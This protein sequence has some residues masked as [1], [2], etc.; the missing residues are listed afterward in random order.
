MRAVTAG[1][2]LLC[3]GAEAAT[4]ASVRSDVWVKS[5]PE[6]NTPDPKD[7]RRVHVSIEGCGALANITKDQMIQ[8]V[9]VNGAEGIDLQDIAQFD[10]FRAHAN[11]ELRSLWISFHT[12]DVSWLG[13]RVDVQVR[14]AKG[15]PVI[16]EGTAPLASS[17]SGLT[18]SYAVVRSGGSEAVLHVHNNDES[19]P[20]DLRNLT[21]DGLR[22]PNATATVPA[23]GHA[24]FVARLTAQKRAAQ[25]WTAS[26]ATETGTLGFGGRADVSERLVTGVWPHSTDCP[27][28]GANDQNAAQLKSM[29]VNSVFYH[30]DNFQK[31]CGGGDLHSLVDTLANDTSPNAFHVL[32][33]FVTAE[34]VKPESLKFIDAL[35]IGDEVDGDYDSDH[36]MKALKRSMQ[37][38]QAAP[39][40]LTFQGSKTTRN[41][42]SFAGI[43]DI[44]ASDAY[45]AACAP[46]MLAVVLPLPVDYPYKYLRNARDNHAP[47]PFWGY[48]QLYSDAWTYQPNTNEI[49]MQLGQAVAAGSKGLMFFQSY[50]KFLS[51]KKSV[52]DIGSALKSI[53]AVGQVI[54][55]G[56]VAGLGVST[57][58]TVGKD[59]LIE[60]IRSPEQVLV[61]V[62]NIHAS[63]YSNLLCHTVILDGHWKINDLHLDSIDLDLTTAPDVSGLG[64]WGEAKD[65][66]LQ[67]LSDVTVST[68]GGKVTLSGIDVHSDM[69]LRLFVADVSH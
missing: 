12:H 65:G 58:G 33:D 69:P 8:S 14:Q 9:T 13:S 30:F 21:F 54:H 22:V 11:T 63:G 10:W 42:G 47:L 51:Q 44:Q 67:P 4:Y 50:A 15:G 59:V 57:S 29:G 18:L 23:G 48:G 26:I 2:S 7:G 41:V 66:A 68:S 52:G 35:F 24:T 36:L 43:T 19:S 60:V 27:L 28:P 6:S 38:Q 49:I 17:D 39:N 37:A 56:D 5:L 3:L 46:T 62:V 40:T 61:V 53:L 32:T 45:C 25:V 55:Q 1:L 31:N 16:C 34:S 64:N 20:H